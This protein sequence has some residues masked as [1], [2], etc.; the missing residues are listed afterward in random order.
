MARTEQRGTRLCQELAGQRPSQGMVLIVQFNNRI[1]A[2]YACLGYRPYVSYNQPPN[3]QILMMQR[4]SALKALSHPWLNENLSSSKKYDKPLHRSVV[5]RIQ[6]CLIE[7]S[8]RCSI[9]NPPYF[10]QLALTHDA[11]QNTYAEICTQQHVQ[12]TCPRM[13]C[14]R[15]CQNALL[16]GQ[17]RSWRGSVQ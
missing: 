12:A 11:C 16:K 6:V 7:C 10:S 15:P 1:Y 3:K 5:Q 9:V 14:S 8:T 13:H 4:P 17:V 2:I